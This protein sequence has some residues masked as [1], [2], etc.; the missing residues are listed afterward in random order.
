MKKVIALLMVLLA[1]ACSNETVFEDRDSIAPYLGLTSLEQLIADAEVIVR[2]SLTKTAAGAVRVVYE[3]QTETE[4]VPV[5]LFT[6]RVHE[7]LMGFGGNTVKGFITELDDMRSS[8]TEARLLAANLRSHHN[9]EWDSRQAIVILSNGATGLFP[10]ASA[11]NG[12]FLGGIVPD[13]YSVASIRARTWLPDAAA[14]SSELTGSSGQSFMLAPP[15]SS[16]SSSVPLSLAP[17]ASRPLPSPGSTIT[18]AELKAKVDGIKAEIAAGDGTQAYKD[19]VSEKYRI[20]ELIKDIPDS[21]ET[22]ALD[23]GLPAGTPIDDGDS[24]FVESSDTYGRYWIDGADKDYFEIKTSD[25][26]K[27]DDELFVYDRRTHTVRPLSAGTY[28]FHP[29]GMHAS[30]VI[31]NLSSPEEWN[32]FTF[33]IEVTAPVGIA[34]EAMFDPT[35]VDGAVKAVSVLKPYTATGADAA[36]VSDIS[37]KSGTLKI[38]LDPVT[39]HTGHVL[40]FIDVDGDV[41]LSLALSGATVDTANKTLSWAVSSQPWKSGDKMMLRIRPA[42]PAPAAP[43]GLTAAAG[44]GS[45]TLA[46]NAST[47]STITRYEYQVRWAGVGWGEWTA[48]SGSGAATASHVVTG[49]TNGTEYRFHLRAVNVSGA[50]TVAPNADPWYVKA[51]PAAPLPAAPSGLAA[52]AGKGSVRLTWN[53][54]TD[55]SITRYEYQVRWA[56]VGWGEWTAIPNSGSSTTS[57]VVTGL[58]GGTEYRFH[59]RAVNAT[60]AGTVAPNAAP[61]YVSAT[62]T[63]PAKRD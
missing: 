14:G 28:R 57:Y 5:V 30:R 43:S 17:S 40:N 46:W 7:Y 6:F 60:G 52:T 45:V 36:T 32:K 29:N 10:D 62:P 35:T 58:T 24:T 13:S 51:T 21:S 25:I 18:L 61:W 23:S 56:G 2:V 55:S 12:Y 26:E 44:N 42:P 59:L 53:A 16:G 37:W 3:G 50:G 19:C 31:C 1:T 34:Y 54:S 38:K 48:I 11:T 63:A 8:E 33:I 47:D 27:Y 39:A 49:L 9:T 41:A 20:R 22:V 4:Y 15:T